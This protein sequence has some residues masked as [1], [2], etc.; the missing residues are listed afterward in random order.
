MLHTNLNYELILKFELLILRLHN[1]NSYFVCVC[2]WS[3]IYIVIANL[4]NCFLF[5]CLPVI[6]FIHSLEEN[7]KLPKGS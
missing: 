5:Q 6:I 3:Q 1:E 7:C 2:N 4:H